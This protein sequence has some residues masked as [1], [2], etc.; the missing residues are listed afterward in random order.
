M[1]VSVRRSYSAA[2]TFSLSLSRLDI[3]KPPGDIHRW[4]RTNLVVTGL[5]LLAFV[6][7]PVTGTPCNCCP[8]SNAAATPERWLWCWR[9]WMAGCRYSMRDA[10]LPPRKHRP[11]RHLSEAAT[12]LPQL[13]PSQ[14]TIPNLRQNLW[15]QPSICRAQT[16]IKKMLAVQQS[17]IRT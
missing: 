2:G 17:T 5:W 9:G 6:Q 12:R 7:S 4:R 14:P 10:L 16:Q 11:V 8:L 1:G 13:P 3:E 15:L